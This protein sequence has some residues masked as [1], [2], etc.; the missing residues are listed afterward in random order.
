[1][2]I[3]LR[4]IHRFVFV[5]NIKDPLATLLNP[6]PRL[7]EAF[8]LSETYSTKSTIELTKFAKSNGSLIISDNGNFSRMKSIAK[9]FQKKGDDLLKRANKDILLN[10][11]IENETMQKRNKLM[12]EIQKTVENE[13]N[14][15]DIPKVIERQLKCNPDY[16]IGMEDFTIPI[17]HLCNILHPIYR[18]KPKSIKTFQKK[19]Q[20]IYL[21]EQNGKYGFQNELN[22]KL[23]FLVY[24]AYDYNSAKQ[25]ASINNKVNSEG[26]AI[27]FGATLASRSY[28][29]SIRIGK[30]TYKFPESLPESYLLSIALVLGSISGDKRKLPSHILGLGTPI[31]IILIATL[32]RD[33]KVVSI[34]S[35]A[36]FKD[37]DD[38]NI[39]GSKD[40]YLKMDMYK[41][42]A[43]ALVNNNPYHSSSPWFK[44]FDS[45]FPSNWLGLSLKLD[46]QTDTDINELT[47]KLKNSPKLLEKFTP[48][49]SPM[50]SG[51][52]VLI[53]KARI[54]RAGTNFWVLK[55]ICIEVR[56]RK[57]NIFELNKWVNSEILRYEKFASPKWAT[58]VRMGFNIINDSFN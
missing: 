56:K 16:M 9:K 33:S 8:L 39:Y 6:S 17:L 53:R 22:K 38:G 25:A 35:T 18:P 27:S 44:W 32:L 51:N 1:M 14:T 12:I 26:I 47:A 52:D 42:V 30:K 58:A 5:S 43:Y 21:N 23:K 34:D 15:L 55:K 24:H 36:T 57:D 45:Q 48:F 2:K 19:T 4:L 49:F 41:V 7:M 11:S 54:A 29:T 13:Q 40:A 28:I 20:Q 46:V 31:L 37:A 10:G 3:P 50:R